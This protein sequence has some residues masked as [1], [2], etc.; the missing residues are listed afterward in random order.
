MGDDTGTWHF[1]LVA[2]WWAEVNPLEA[3][4]LDFYRGEIERSGGPAL[5]L[6]CGTGRLL[7]PL[8]KAGLDVDGVDISADM[9]ARARAA[10]EAAGIDAAGRLAQGTFAGFAMPRRYRTIVC[11]DSFGIGGDREADEVALANVR[12]H[13]LPGGVFTFSLDRAMPDVLARMTA[14]VATY[15]APWPAARDRGRLADGDELEL[16]VRTGAFDPA[17]RVERMDMRARLWRDGHVIE[18][19]AGS[20]RWSMYFADEVVAM[21]REAGFGQVEVEGRYTWRPAEPGDETVVVRA[22][23]VE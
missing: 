3:D 11:C 10:A 22:R 7:V 20:L 12:R 8:L 2:R 15:P 9:L 4:E 5:D 1:G 14:A 6:G 16:L 17:T 19:E 13:L 21:A 23:A 18:E